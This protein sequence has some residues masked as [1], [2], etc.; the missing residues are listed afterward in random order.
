MSTMSTF[1]NK[2]VT[3]SVKYKIKYKIFVLQLLTL[4]DPGNFRQLTNPGGGFKSP[5]PPYDLENYIVNL[6]HIIHV[7]LTRCFR[8]DPIGF[9]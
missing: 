4:S 5:P 6:H 7:N 1:F 8:H 2:R 3:F 9:F